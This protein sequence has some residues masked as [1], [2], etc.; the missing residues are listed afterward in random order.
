MPISPYFTSRLIGRNTYIIQGEGCDSYLLLGDDEALM[1]DAGESVHNIREY[2]EKLTD[3]P[4]SRVIN[5]H[6]HFDHT[7]GNGFF[8]VIYGTKG[9]SRSAKNTMGCDPKAYKLD[10][11]FTLVED[12]EIIKLKGRDLQ[13]IVLDCH[14]PE[15]IA[16][17]DRTNRILFPGD[18][19]ECGQVLLLPGYAEEPGQIHAKPAASVETYLHAMEKLNSFRSEFDTIFP[20]HNGSPLDPIYLDWYIELA[21]MVIKGFEGIEDCSTPSYNESAAHFPLKDANYR[22]A[23]Y[24]GASLVYCKDLIFD[25]DYANADKLAPATRLHLIC[26]DFARQ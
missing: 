17:L 13:I 15:N 11:T 5:T 24:K 6:S 21:K 3:L 16:I 9:I 25:K 4:V 20:A 19:L 18:E 22:R 7:G 12:G 23:E 8:D 1:I 14:A 26:K 2:A 10:Y